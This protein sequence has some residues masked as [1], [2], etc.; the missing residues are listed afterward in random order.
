MYDSSERSS[1]RQY[2]RV[3]HP[4]WG[5][6]RGARGAGRGRGVVARS[7][8]RARNVHDYT[9]RVDRAGAFLKVERAARD[10]RHRCDV[11]HSWPVVCPAQRISLRIPCT[12]KCV[13]CSISGRVGGP[14]TKF[15]DPGDL[16]AGE[17]YRK[18][19]VV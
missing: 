18:G 17:R 12:F 6:G 15:S 3:K 19:L 8:P 5:A 10:V 7:R 11:T 9:S 16:D 4:P 13:P 14:V 2:R 1:C